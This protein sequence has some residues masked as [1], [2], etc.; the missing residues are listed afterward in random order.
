M[1]R[2]VGKVANPLRAPSGLLKSVQVFTGNGTWTKPAGIRR[3]IVEVVGGGGAGGGAAATGA[4]QV[5]VGGGGG[6]GGCAIALVDV[7][8]VASGAVTVGAGGTGVPS[9]QTF[10]L[11]AL[12]NQTLNAY[13]RTTTCSG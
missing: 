7:S 13:R 9:L 12:S 5:S 8:S 3:V 11:R 2:F 1:R 4:G 10:I 6:G